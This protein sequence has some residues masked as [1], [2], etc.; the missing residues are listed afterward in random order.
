MALPLTPGRFLHRVR[1][2]FPTAVVEVVHPFHGED[3]QKGMVVLFISLS[4]FTF[5]PVFFRGMI[6]IVK[7][8]LPLP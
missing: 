6:A 2:G 4:F 1:G 3:V 5:S 8:C 7:K